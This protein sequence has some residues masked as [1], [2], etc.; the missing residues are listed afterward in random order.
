MRLL[1]VGRLVR[2]SLFPSAAADIAAGIVLGAGVWPGGSTPFLLILASLAI[3][4]G[5][6]ALNDW[7]DRDHDGRT[8]PDRPIPSGDIAPPMALGLGLGGLVLG[9]ALAFALSPRVGMVLAG[10]A[11]C[12]ALYDL[13]GR[14]PWRGPSMLALCR[15]GNL[16]AGLLFGILHAQGAGAGS[17]DGRLL[18]PLAYGLYVF[19]VSRLGR[20]EDGEDTLDSDQTPRRI[21]GGIAAILLATGILGGG[22]VEGSI[23][24]RMLPVAV[25]LAS[26][27]GIVQVSH[28]PEPFTPQRIGMAMGACLRRLLIVSC[29]AALASPGPAGL[30]VAAGILLGYPISASL[31]RTFPPS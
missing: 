25:A 9:P 5:G 30:W 12:A 29:I 16:Y 2:L 18:F 31:K 19:V 17:L 11:L 3:Y 28:S 20:L 4:H 8:R 1:A 10:V 6:L 15:A 21:L 22:L 26:A 27:W 24:R 7:G 23:L 13:W 14:G